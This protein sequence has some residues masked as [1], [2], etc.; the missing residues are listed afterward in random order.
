MRR[1]I[2][3]TWV[4]GSMSNKDSPLLMLVTNSSPPV[5]IIN[6]IILTIIVGLGIAYNDSRA[7]NSSTPCTF[8]FCAASSSEVITPTTWVKVTLPRGVVI[9]SSWG[10]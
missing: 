5:L 2:T 6:T 3:Q 8:H 10:S 7:N 1:Y 9:G 4:S